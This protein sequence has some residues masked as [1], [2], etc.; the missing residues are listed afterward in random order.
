VASDE[1]I[2]TG[3]TFD[4]ID[5]ATEHVVVPVATDDGT[6]LE[7][8]PAAACRST[9]MA[10]LDESAGLYRVSAD[11]SLAVPFD[12]QADWA[13]ALMAARR[14]LAHQL[15]GL[16]A[17]LLRIAVEHVTVREQFGR[18][19]G[20]N[21]AVQHRL[22]DAKVELSAAEELTAEAWSTATPLAA[23][24]AK[25]MASRAMNTVGAHGQQVLGGIGFTWEHSWR[26]PLRRGMLVSALLGSADECDAEIGRELIRSGVV[27]IGALTGGPA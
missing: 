5:G 18:P 21:Q 9:P 24:A 14:A 2:V 27:R 15:I 10:G 22:A 13:Q 17:D 26:H 12:A 8:I 6:Q 25:A 23:A 4:E 19:L 3:I 1:T 20:A 7:V 11:R 16:S